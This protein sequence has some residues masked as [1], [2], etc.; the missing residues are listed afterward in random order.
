MKEGKKMKNELNKNDIN[1]LM[2]YLNELSNKRSKELENATDPFEQDYIKNDYKE[3]LK[4]YQKL[5][6]IYK[7]L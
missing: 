3:I 1:N 7:N 6:N 4:L 5:D 2:D